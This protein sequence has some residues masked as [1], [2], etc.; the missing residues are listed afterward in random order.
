[1]TPKLRNEL[2]RHNIKNLYIKRDKRS[3]TG[4]SCQYKD[5]RFGDPRYN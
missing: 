4:F 5:P 2:N 3:K 1:M